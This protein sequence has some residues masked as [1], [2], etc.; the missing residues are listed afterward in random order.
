MAKSIASLFGPSA[1]EIV[2]AQQEAGKQ[3]QQQQLQNTLAAYQD[4]MARQFYQSGYN[5][6]SG[7]GNIAGA[8]FGDA[9]MADPRLAKN[10]QLRKILGST[11]VDDL[12][13]VGKLNKLSSELAKAGLAQ[14]AMFFSDR[15]TSLATS[16][17]QR[18]FK[19]REL[20]AKYGTTKPTDY[21]V[22][23]EDGSISNVEQ[24]GNR[25]FNS[26]TGEEITDFSLV[27][28][29]GELKASG[30]AKPAT[31]LRLKQRFLSDSDFDPTVKDDIANEIYRRSIRIYN[32]SR[33]SLEESQ[34]E[35]Q[36]YNEMIKDKIIIPSGFAQKNPFSSWKYNPT[37]SGTTT[38]STS[39]EAVTDVDRRENIRREYARN[40]PSGSILSGIT[41]TQI[42]ELSDG[43]RFELLIDVNGNVLYE[44]EIK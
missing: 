41:T 2:Y 18:D 28:K 33:G 14:E 11:N 43:R 30:E 31:K 24:R 20:E 39:S 19:E 15:A 29:A 6:A 25:Y 42:R 37:A 10:I 17:Y 27:R 8:L 9:P 5:I 44:R 40:N 22:L 21:R 32:N 3:R 16:A 34:A 7:V 36:A 26:T 13:D 38:E 1:E 23:N 12:N 4:P 35:Q